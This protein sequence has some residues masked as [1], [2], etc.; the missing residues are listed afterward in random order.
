LAYSSSAL[1]ACDGADAVLH[2]TEWREFR[3][4]RPADLDA[5]VRERNILDGRSVLDAA[6][7]REAG[8]QFRALGRP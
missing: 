1:E 4:L 8:W 3:E 2:L 7:W 5:V 6:T